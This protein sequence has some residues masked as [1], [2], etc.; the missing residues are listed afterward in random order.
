MAVIHTKAEGVKQPTEEKPVDRKTEGVGMYR[1][2]GNEQSQSASRRTGK[3]RRW[4][5]K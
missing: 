3:T 4:V 2:K 1:G 5:G